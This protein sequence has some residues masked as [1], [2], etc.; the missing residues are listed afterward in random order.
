MMSNAR[1]WGV[2]ALLMLAMTAALAW[3]L[4]QWNLQNFT[5]IVENRMVLLNE[6]R[7]GALQ[8]Y[9]STA[10]SE[11]QFWSSSQQVVDAQKQLNALWAANGDVEVQS[12]TLRTAY[13]E[14][15]PDTDAHTR[16]M[17][18]SQD[19]PYVRL[20]QQLHP[21]F[22]LFV[23]QR[24]Y[25]DVFLVGME[26][27]VLY[28]V[29]K[30]DDFGSDL[31]AGPYKDSGLGRAYRK[32]MAAEGQVILTDMSSYAPS[33]GAP[34]MFIAQLI[35]DNDGSALGVIAFQLPTDRILDILAY[36]SGM[37]ET[38][39]TYVVGADK[40]MRSDSRFYEGSTVLQQI[41]DTVAVDLALDGQ[42]G[43]QYIRDYRD[44]EVMSAY[45]SIPV[46]STRWVVLAEV[47]REEVI[48]LAAQD[49]PQLAPALALIY[50]LSLWS[51]WYW[52]GRAAGGEESPMS[53]LDFDSHDPAGDSSLIS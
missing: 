5:R 19:T 1:F 21:I 35:K 29:E 40:L 53:Q 13:I 4:S 23:S 22:S 14:N 33:A 2:S 31:K 47:N 25:Y 41:V 50:G 44:V 43:V 46:G 18:T 48:S 11:L 7:R 32:A 12:R 3:G 10:Q 51:I 42:E 27:Y 17:M 49:R 20:H 36:T 34:A 24:G 8:L 52:R 26:G 45:A 28:S 30:E 9:F 16:E 37:G 38:G 6:L 39:E 15:N